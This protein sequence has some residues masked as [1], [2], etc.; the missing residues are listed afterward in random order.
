MTAMDLYQKVRG[1]IP[2][3]V[4]WVRRTQVNLDVEPNEPYEPDQWQINLLLDESL[5]RAAC[6]G[7][8][9][10]KSHGI[11]WD[12]AHHSL[13]RTRAKT[14]LV[15]R[16][17]RQSKELIGY[18][19]ESL[20]N[21]KAE[22]ED[23]NVY[24]IVLKN[25]SEIHAV[26]GSGASIRGF[27]RITK[28]I[29]D[30]AAFCPD[31]LFYAVEPMVNI[32]KG[33]ITLLSSADATY[34]FFWNIMTGEDPEWHRYHITAYDCPRYDKDDLDRKRKHLP[35]RIF[36]REYLAQFVAPQGVWIPED[37]RKRAA[38]DLVD[39]LDQEAFGTGAEMED[40]E[41]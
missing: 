25:G 15:S 31:E 5:R 14:L 40:F 39:P 24:D 33:Q 26:P 4:E 29:V 38:A 3:P 10:G 36:K 12:A 34:G 37:M 7:R 35:E 13:F 41:I 21:A 6:C 30:E 1:V 2:D 17:L 28:L 18:V 16:A 27:S 32:S 11:G 19:K 22:F 8:Q 23:D 20:Y 9:V